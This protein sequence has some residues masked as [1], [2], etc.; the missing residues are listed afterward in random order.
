MTVTIYPTPGR[1]LP[2]LPTVER[3]VTKEEAEELVATGAYQFDKPDEP[4][5]PEADQAAPT[6]E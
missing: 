2:G 3:T 1:M 4:E 5:Q 6:E